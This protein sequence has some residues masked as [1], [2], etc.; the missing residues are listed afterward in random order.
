M[1][2]GGKIEEFSEKYFLGLI[3]YR[4]IIILASIVL[5]AGAVFLTQKLKLRT[6]LAE[7]LPDRLESV[8]RSKEAKARLGGTGLL[9]IGVQSPSYESNKKFVETLAEKLKPEVGKTLRY[10]EYRY[11]DVQEYLQK[12]ALHYLDD[13]QLKKLNSELQK[14]IESRKEEAFG[15][16]LGLSEEKKQDT[17]SSE[18][19]FSS[20]KLDPNIRKFLEYRDAYLSVDNGKVMALSLRPFG[21]G[22]QADFTRKL[23]DKIK[24]YVHELNPQS[25]HPEMRVEFSGNVQ[26]TLEEYDTLKEDLFDTALHL[27]IL[28]LTAI[29]LFVWS[30]PALIALGMSLIV[31]VIYTFAITQLS[32]GYLN[33]QTAFMASIIVGTGINYGIIY[34]NRFKVLRES[35]SCIDALNGAI[36]DTL[37]ATILGSSSTAVAFFSLLAA[38][39]KGLSQFG[40]IGGVGISFCWIVSY[41]LLPIMIYEYEKRGFNLY[42]WKNPLAPVALKIGYAIATASVRYWRPILGVLAVTTFIVG[43]GMLVLKK[44]PIEYNFD[45]VRTRLVYDDDFINFRKRTNRVF[46]TSLY[47]S[48]IFAESPEAAEEICPTIRNIKKNLPPEKDTLQSCSSLQDL[49]PREQKMTPERIRLMKE[50]KSLLQN[51]LLRF[52][53]YGHL[54]LE[55]GKHATLDKPDKSEIPEQLRRR[56]KE[57]DGREGLF[58]FVG[59]LATTPLNDGRNLLLFTNTLTNIDLPKSKERVSA[60]GESFIF[61]DIL[62]G[63]QR[64][65]AVISALSFISVL[66]HCFIFAGGFKNGLFLCFCLGISTI[67]MLGTQGWLGIKYNFFNFIALPLTF[68]I[69]IDYPVNI[70]MPI[71]QNNRRNYS[72][73][74]TTFG[75]AVLLCSITTFIGYWTLI[76]A[77]SQALAT[78]ARIAIIGEVACVIGAI[79]LVPVLLQAA[80]KGKAFDDPPSH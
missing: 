58:A 52:S 29:F 72:Y 12:Y 14:E 74:M 43:Y 80:K 57:L 13:E 79:I 4:K 48:V 32:I 75:T 23:R 61:A 62:K 39:N 77:K 40:I 46:P 18:S 15:T 25:F 5:F 1:N 71:R 10:F 8:Q 35:M 11:T 3:R 65:A 42:P 63:I 51:R 60:A 50:A 21:S 56:F 49:F 54:L 9:L 27:T 22:L 76:S 53:D 69:G 70:F 73:V 2:F 6:D 66:I 16:F 17:S 64:D 47:P 19:I 68:G 45:N 37:A 28:T 26:Q 78:F 24:T 20:E 31:A 36:K 41:S 55:I 30:I 44:D 67:W 34:L 38:D 7:L 33:T 59:P